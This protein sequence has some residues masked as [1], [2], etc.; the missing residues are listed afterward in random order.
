MSCCG[1]SLQPT[2]PCSHVTFTIPDSAVCTVREAVLKGFLME[3]Q[4]V[5]FDIRYLHDVT[6]GLMCSVLFVVCIV[7]ST[8]KGTEKFGEQWPILKPVITGQCK[9]PRYS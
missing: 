7:A 9:A 5:C 2:M 8:P 4:W 6:P 3:W 1:A